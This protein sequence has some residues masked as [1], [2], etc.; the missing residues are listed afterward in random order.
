MISDHELPGLTD[1]LF[2]PVAFGWIISILNLF[3]NHNGQ[4][5]A[6]ER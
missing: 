3:P 5:A 6:S 2:A 1:D 4:G